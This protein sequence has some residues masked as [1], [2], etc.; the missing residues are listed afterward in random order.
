MKGF[1]LI[2]VIVLT[3]CIFSVTETCE[4]F[5]QKLPADEYTAHLVGHAH[6][7]LVWLWL[8]EET[9]HDVTTNTFEGTMKY[10]DQMPGLTFAQSMAALYEEIE[11]EYPE[12]FKE[13]TR[14]VK[15]ETWQP[16]G[17]M[18]AESDMNMPKGEAIVRQLLLGKTY[19]KEKFGI[20]INVGWLPDTF[21]HSGN[22][23]QIMKRAGI[24]Y[25]ILERCAPEDKTI[26]WWKGIDGSKLLAYVPPGWYLIKVDEKIE[27]LTTKHA[28]L[29]G[30]KDIMFLYG[31]G[32]HGGGPRES[33]VKAI[34]DLWYRDEFPELRFS[35]PRHFFETI[36]KQKQDFPQVSGELNFTFRGCYTTQALIKYYN[37]KMENLLLT[38][39]KFSLNS[40]IHRFRALYPKRDIDEGWKTTLRN[41]FHDILPGSSIGPANDDVHES[42]REAKKRAD[43]ALNFSLETIAGNINTE[44]QGIPVVV[45]NP[46]SW[47][48]SDVVNV[49]LRYLH[50]PEAVRMTDSEGNKVP[51]QIGGCKFR[52]GG[53]DV[54]VVFIADEVPSMGYKL[55][56]ALETSGISQPVTNLRVSASLMSNERFLLSLNPLNGLVKHIQDK[57]YNRDVLTGSGNMLQMLEDIG[58][59]SKGAGPAWSLGWTGNKVDLT[60]PEK[61]EVVENGPV[62]GTVRITH[63]F[64]RSRFVQDI[65]LYSSLPRIDFRLK[66][67]WRERDRMLKV[68]FPV[69]VNNSHATFEIPYGYIERPVNGEEVPALNWIDLSERDYGVSLLNDCKYGFDVDGNVMRMSILRGPLSP[70]PGADEG[71]HYLAYSLYPHA[72][73]FKDALS[74]RA[75]EEFNNPLIALPTLT[76]EGKMPASFSFASVQPS[77]V[78]LMAMKEEQGYW[79]RSI[80]IR[81]FESLG[82]QCVARLSLPMPV[83][84]VEA[85]LLEQEIGNVLVENNVITVPM[86][87]FEIKTLKINLK[88]G[89]RGF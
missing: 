11:K 86:S 26:F 67:E 62:R 9:I 68:A 38:A 1:K 51:T 85:D 49:K 63:E 74:V 34:R 45:F 73:D 79:N 82:K 12:L 7:D 39:E 59:L 70:D 8:W 2:C 13:I 76:H 3:N 61:I 40:R 72:G 33:D 31:A 18:W 22:I 69:N 19:F 20:D 84:A 6:I 28:D 65:I 64:N 29:S 75:G 44:G 17:G 4:F 24:D 21:G 77:N 14:R 30:V 57:Q 10:M 71:M 56:R 81:L 53:Y 16:V 60:N 48:R 23:P 89:W 54:R 25:Y 80:I 43:R 50:E 46:L 66:A 27:E 32:D 78:L 47:E 36:L 37:R 58:S 35:T 55:Y 41:Q 52:N 83:D 15:N 5:A 42:Y 87:P 88:E